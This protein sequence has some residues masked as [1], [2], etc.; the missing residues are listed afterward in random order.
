MHLFTHKKAGIF[1][2]PI[3]FVID[4]AV[5]LV[6]FLIAVRYV[7]FQLDQTTFEKRYLANDIALLVDALYASPHPIVYSYPQQT[8]WFTYGFQKKGIIVSEN[9]LLASKAGAT[10]TPDANA[11]FPE[12]DLVPEKPIAD[13]NSIIKTFLK[14]LDWFTSPKFTLPEGASVKINFVR[15]PKGID[16]AEKPFS[17]PPFAIPCPILSVKENLGD[18]T[19]LLDAGDEK[20]KNPAITGSIIATAATILKQKAKQLLHTRQGTIEAPANDRLPETEVDAAKKQADI[21]I[22]V[23]TGNYADERLVLKAY[24][25][26]SA[27]PELE[28]KSKKLA[29]LAANEFGKKLPGLEGASLIESPFAGIPADKIGV[30]LKIGNRNIPPDQ[31]PL[32]QPSALSDMGISL[33]AAIEKYTTT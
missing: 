11:P 9:T 20:E 7:D 23:E 10:F 31:N 21:T 16:V 14:P 15:T 30:V 24:Y 28:M 6:V 12:K 13:S 8:F 25:A 19:F 26:P 33:A 27:N 2:K 1:E 3:W 29:C 5:A 4:L 22:R 17:L 32:A 18:L